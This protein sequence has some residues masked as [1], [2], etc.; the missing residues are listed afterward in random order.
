MPVFR[1]VGR[2]RAGVSQSGEIE[3]QDQNSAVALL[4]QRQI[5]VTSLRAKPKNLE[6]TI[7]GLSGRVSEKE[8]VIFTRQFATMIEADARSPS[9]EIWMG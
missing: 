9:L 6:I 7:P 3:A 2:T 5:M 8:I 4:R 1:Y